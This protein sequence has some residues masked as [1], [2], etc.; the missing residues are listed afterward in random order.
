MMPLTAATCHGP[1]GDGPNGPG[2]G[3]GSEW[4]FT[5]QTRR[6]VLT[7]PGFFGTA[8][9]A[10]GRVKEL[11]RGRSWSRYFPVMLFACAEATTPPLKATQRALTLLRGLRAARSRAVK[12]ILVIDDDARLREHY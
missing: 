3:A 5:L 12:R 7:A 8:T 2:P 1:D 4:D 6:V 10:G 11:R 9:A